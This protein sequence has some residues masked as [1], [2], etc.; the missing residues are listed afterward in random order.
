LIFSEVV[1]IWSRFIS[2]VDLLANCLWKWDLDDTAEIW[3]STP[4]WTWPTVQL[5]EPW[6]WFWKV[7]CHIQQVGYF[8]H[9]IFLRMTSL[10]F[11]RFCSCDGVSDTTWVF[12]ST[13]FFDWF[14]AGV[15]CCLPWFNDK[16]FKLLFLFRDVFLRR[17]R[18][19]SCSYFWIS[20]RK[21]WFF[22]AE[23]QLFDI[24]N[25]FFFFK[26]FLFQFTTR[27]LLIFRYRNFLINW[28]LQFLHWNNVFFNE[29]FIC[30]FYWHFMECF[31]SK[32][33]FIFIMKHWAKIT[34][35]RTWF[36]LFSIFR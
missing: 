15:R 16:L 12:R 3:S 10:T 7:V 33:F 31:I 32:I 19:R 17:R 5:Y 26:I 21:N 36:L 29:S 30:N 35:L 6:S 18:F 9:F 13:H 4:I 24:L 8:G 34:S 2:L 11:F 14:I 1:F 28:F 25:L 20:L 22:S 23:F 27:L